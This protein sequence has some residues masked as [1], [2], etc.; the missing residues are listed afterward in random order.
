MKGTAQP[1]HEPVELARMIA[2][3]AKRIDEMPTQQRETFDRACAV[4]DVHPPVLLKQRR[5]VGHE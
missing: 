5:E 1:R 2:E 4:F 3:I